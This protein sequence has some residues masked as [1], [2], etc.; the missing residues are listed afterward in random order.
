MTHQ[1][2]REAILLGPVFAGLG[3]LSNITLGINTGIIVSIPEWTA[4]AAEEQTSLKGPGAQE[5]IICEQ[6]RD[7][8]KDYQK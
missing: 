6:P 2:S 8:S 1:D 7:T 3:T 4:I 5:K